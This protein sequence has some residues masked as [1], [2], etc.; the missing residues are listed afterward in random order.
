VSSPGSPIRWTSLAPTMNKRNEDF[1][2]SEVR[3]ENERF[4][5][6]K[7]VQE[8]LEKVAREDLNNIDMIKKQM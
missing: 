4:E 2:Q 8:N 1:F 7:R 5:Q 3:K 6:L